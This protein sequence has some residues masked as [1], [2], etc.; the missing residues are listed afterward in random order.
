MKKNS[1]TFDVSHLQLEDIKKY[2][3][4]FKEISYKLEKN[5]IRYTEIYNQN[6]EIRDLSFYVKTKDNT[7]Y[8]PLTL[9]NKERPEISFYNYPIEIF[10]EKKIDEELNQFLNKTLNDIKKQNKVKNICFKVK[11][12][13]IIN[14]ENTPENLEKIVSDIYISLNLSHHEIQSNFKQSLRTIL[15]KK[16]ETLEYQ[17]ID[18]ENYKRNEIHKMR[19]MHL[20]VIGKETRSKESWLQNER[21]ILDGNAFIVKATFENKPISYSFFYFNEITCFYLSS[22]SLREYFK[23]I[24]NITHSS[25]WHAIVYAKKKC[26]YFYIGSTTVYSKKK[27]LEKEVNIDKFKKQF[28]LESEEYCI[29]ND[30]PNFF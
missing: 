30:V 19:E 2:I 13:N 3:K 1:D 20:I 5:F 23:T 28:S 12:N 11:K 18:K 21:M 24:K 15:R 26:D 7:I 22:C 27:I 25:L 16:Y 4:K 9:F 6:P 8:C 29:F 10:S 17:I 14:N